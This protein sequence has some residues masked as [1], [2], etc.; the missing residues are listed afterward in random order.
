MTQD[1]TLISD[2]GRSR[3]Q[4]P[5]EVA[6]YVRELIISGRVCP[7]EYLRL[8]RIAEAVGVS[9]TPVREGLLALRSEGF[10]ELVPRKGFV[11]AAFTEQDVRDLFWVQAQ[12]ASELAA[13]AAVRITPEQLDQLE[14]VLV[15]E[16]RA[17]LDESQRLVDLGHAFHRAINRAAGSRRL[18]FL[19]GAAARQLPPRFFL[20]MAGRVAGA[21]EDHRGLVEALHRGDADRARE[22]MHRHVL[23]GA[24]ELI[25]VLVTSGLWAEQESAS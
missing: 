17:G 7:G 16:E 13:R 3:Q 10:V 8:D 4:L 6:A 24:D 15:A 12:L 21:R 19:L 25:E 9:N 14:A 5:E 20:S 1:A 18:A 23:A 2:R 11:A 22:L